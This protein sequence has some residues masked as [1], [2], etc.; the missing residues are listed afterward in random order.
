MTIE[1]YYCDDIEVDYQ[2]DKRVI[3]N[4]KVKLKIKKWRQQTK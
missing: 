3:I 4:I 1:V 2:D